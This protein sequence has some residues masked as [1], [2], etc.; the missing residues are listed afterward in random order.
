MKWLK[1]KSIWGAVIL[2]VAGVIRVVKPEWEGGIETVMALAAAL[3]IIGVR[4][5]IEKAKNG[6]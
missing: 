1:S 4:H 2:G 3:G 5:G 6:K